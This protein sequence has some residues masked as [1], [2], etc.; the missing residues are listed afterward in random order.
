MNL[1]Y[2]YSLFYTNLWRKKEENKRIILRKIFV[3]SVKETSE[4]LY[5]YNVY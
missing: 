3:L 5:K 4:V 1:K 2:L